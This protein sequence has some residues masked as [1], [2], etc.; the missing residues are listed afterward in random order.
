[1]DETTESC[2]TWALGASS[3][4]ALVELA[5]LARRLGT[6]VEPMPVVEPR[7]LLAHAVERAADGR[8]VLLAVTEPPEPTW[9]VTLGEARHRG[10]G[11]CVLAVHDPGDE[12][13]LLRGLAA[14]LGLVAT[15]GLEAA[16]MAARLLDH[17]VPAPWQASL[18]H[19]PSVDR[20]WLAPVGTSAPRTG[21]LRW[22]RGEQGDLLLESETGSLRLGPAPQLGEALGALRA[23]HGASW[24]A[25]PVVE[26]VDESAVREVIFGP[27]RTLSDPASK[28][29]LTPYGLPVPL[30]RLCR[31][32]SRTA[33]EAAR[34]G[35]PVRIA[36]ASPDVRVWEH[37]ELVADGVDNAARAKDVY[38][39]MT[40]M[41][42]L[43]VPDARI[44]GVTVSATAEARCY[45]RLTMWPAP[46][47][48][49]LVRLGFADPHG[50]AAGDEVL[51]FLPQPLR[52]LEQSLRR[53]AAR[54]LLLPTRERREVLRNLGDVLLR[55]AAFVDR[56]REEVEQVHVEPLAVLPGGQVELREAAVSV[57]E[58][59]EREVYGASSAG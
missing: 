31:S 3:A 1:M 59:F 45:L 51:S 48:R 21:S 7:D 34:I 30:E 53:L 10:G 25:M 12:A 19:L 22:R 20:V 9:L 14:D 13:R 42:R 8:P 39:Q 50:L 43:H 6:S 28:R 4:E 40:A 35:F 33:T 32:A 29:A 41:A 47:G 46:E 57:S 11:P 37:P 5:R 38:R 54:E 24:P 15:T 23:A 55:L 36:L 52:R 49:A 56:W 17:D 26:G 58:A 44:L 2:R 16:A 18:R 27:R